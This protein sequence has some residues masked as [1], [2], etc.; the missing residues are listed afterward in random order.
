MKTENPLEKHIE[1]VVCKY[2]KSRGVL[3]YKFVSPAQRHVPD[4][5]FIFMGHT[6]FV[7]FK[8]KGQKSTPAQ[9]LEHERMRAHGV[10]VHV[11]DSVEQG[12]RVIDLETL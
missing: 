7:E 12:K 11:V 8:R 3:V 5:I 4:R 6:F 1:G 9:S 10:V 2:A